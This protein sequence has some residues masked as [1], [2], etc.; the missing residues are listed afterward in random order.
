[1][2]QR[3]KLTLARRALGEIVEWAEE[4]PDDDLLAQIAF[5]ARRALTASAPETALQAPERLTQTQEQL[6]ALA[7]QLA[8]SH[9]DAAAELGKRLVEEAAERKK[10]R[11]FGISLRV[12]FVTGRLEM[13]TG[14]E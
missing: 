3:D 14:G 10:L 2:N 8:A 9:P 1:M 6:L 12:N 7:R 5:A 11:G 4:R 13:R